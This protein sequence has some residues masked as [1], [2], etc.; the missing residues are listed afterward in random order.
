MSRC[1]W[2]ESCPELITY[3]D[4]EWGKINHSD[5]YHFELLTLEGAQAGRSW[6]T[7]LKRREGYRTLFAQFDPEIIATL[8]DERLDEIVSDAR[9]IRHRLKV[10]SVRK[11]AQI[12]L[13]IQEEF[14]TFDSYLWRFV[15]G[16]PIVRSLGSPMPASTSLSDTISKDLKKR[17]MSFVGSTIIYAYLQAV[18][19][20][21][22]HDA[23][24]FLCRGRD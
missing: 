4:S 5:L 15:N 13:K 11:N 21:D 8:T 10:Y 19:V 17:G 22:D 24:C 3:H 23:D 14:G 6:L 1:A 7:I 20:V 12:F 9:I 2:A 16:E 18:G